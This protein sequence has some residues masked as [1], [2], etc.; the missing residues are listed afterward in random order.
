[1]EKRYANEIIGFNNRM[2]DLHA[3]IGRVQLKRVQAWTAT[4]QR[5]ATFLSENIK[6]VVTPPVSPDS[7]HVFHQYT[8]R[9]VGLDRDKFSEELSKRGIGNGV[10]YPTPIHRLPSF[11]SK[12]ELPTTEKVAAECLSLPVHPSL[13]KR[14]L[15]SIVESV[16]AIA[17]G[18]A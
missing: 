6:G 1:M 7:V 8:I 5:N 4:R 12:V 13:S 2:T 10:Y 3:A 18:G 14:D 17:S 11:S 15:H 9:I 16:N